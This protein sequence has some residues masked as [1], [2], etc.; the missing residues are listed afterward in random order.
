MPD[1]LTLLTAALPDYLHDLETLVSIDCGTRSKR[2]VDAAAKIL[3]ERFADAGADVLDFPQTEYGNMFYAR[4]RNKGR[5]KIFMIGHADT[6]YLDGTAADH[7]F[8]KKG[9]RAYGCGVIDMKAGL[10]NGLFA[11]RA[12]KQSGFDNFA[13]I[14]MFVN[15]EEE[16]GS[17]VSRE[18]YPQFAR[19]ADAALV[20][21]PGRESG[22][23]VSARKG[24]GTYTLTV[25]GKSAHAGVEP[26]K[27]ANAIV[28]LGQ[29]A[30]E[31]HKLN[32]FRTG[33]TL[34]VGQIRGGI[35]TNV[36]PDFAEAKID[37]R[38]LRAQ[39]AS[40]V[41]AALRAVIAQEK[42]AGTRAELSG[43]I[44]KPP[45]EKTPASARLVEIAQ[46]AAR[47][48]GF[49]VEDVLTGG[50]SDGNYTAALGVP[51]LDA[52]GPVGGKAHNAAEE[53][54]DVDSIV[55]RAAMLAKIM[56]RI[57]ER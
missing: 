17:P 45:M 5:A 13:E 42:I 53:Y 24:V 34:N 33:L 14:G 23:I 18:I 8:R 22:A 38:V 30:A 43:G 4:W 3:R 56:M 40:A 57:A 16:I 1:L 51:T 50:G 39:D 52:L 6:V 9:S 11:L 41:E 55:P 2:G 32:G 48:L 37:L 28:A 21:E 47:E 27:G 7:P 49:E 12:L 54:L 36:V 46:S 31:L 19:G 15:S 26:E 35:A 20:L 10:L 29:Y 25:R 44:T